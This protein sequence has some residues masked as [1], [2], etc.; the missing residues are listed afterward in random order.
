MENTLRTSD[1]EREL[2]KITKVGRGKR[3]LTLVAALVGVAALIAVVAF[4]FRGSH[5]ARS[6]DAMTAPVPAGE[7]HGRRQ[8]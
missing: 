3:D 2:R 8:Q 7:W 5:V 6:A 1:V 4:G